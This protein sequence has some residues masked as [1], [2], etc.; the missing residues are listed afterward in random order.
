MLA[1]QMVSREREKE[2]G[3]ILRAPHDIYMCD[4]SGSSFVEQKRRRSRRRR[5]RITSSSAT[6]WMKWEPPSSLSFANNRLSLIVNWNQ[7]NAIGRRQ[8]ITY[9]RIHPIGLAKASSISSK[10]RAPV[11][12]DNLV[13][14]ASVLNPP[15]GPT[16]LDLFTSM[17]Q[18]IYLDHGQK[19]LTMI[20][21]DASETGKSNSK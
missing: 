20:L 12:R 19:V 5:I 15:T 1:V 17:L 9:K 7:L 2:G 21:P 11:K 3:T 4:Q 6:T 8:H 14:G 18:D 10:L 13:V 16:K